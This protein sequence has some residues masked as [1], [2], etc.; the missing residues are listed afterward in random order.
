MGFITLT[1]GFYIVK[2]KTS[3]WKKVHIQI[4]SQSSHFQSDKVFSSHLL[5][6]V[7]IF[8]SHVELTDWQK[9]TTVF[10][11]DENRLIIGQKNQSTF[12]WTE[13]MDVSSSRSGSNGM[14][15]WSNET[16]HFK[17]NFRTQLVQPEIGINAI[18][19]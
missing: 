16:V 4:S 7:E 9:Q 1:N 8:R 13:E 15:L 6:S 14:N 10:L 18:L 11:S 17:M 5:K 19:S 3:C 12:G 2:T